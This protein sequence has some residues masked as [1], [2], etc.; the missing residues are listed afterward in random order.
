MTCTA[1][2]DISIDNITGKCDLKCSFSYKYGNI[3]SIGTNRD[4]YLS[5]VNNDN[6]NGNPPVSYNNT[7][8][9]VSEI[10]LYQPSLHSYRGNKKD[11]EIIIVHQSVN[12]DDN[13]I[14]VC[15]PITA[16][17][18]SGNSL[19]TIIQTIAKNA[20]SSGNKTEIK[21]FSV[22]DWL[23]SKST[24]FYTYQATTP[25][26]PCSN[27]LVNYIVFDTPITISTAAMKILKNIIKA[28]T[29][30]VKTGIEY[31]VNKS[32]A[33]SSTQD[34]E[35]YIDCQPTWISDEK[36]SQT[37]S[38]SSKKLTW[39]DIYTNPYFGYFIVV[40][41]FIIFVS[42]FHFAGKYLFGKKMGKII[43]NETGIEMT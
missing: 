32:G 18:S 2:I 17:S 8:F 3:S 12:G 28:N 20:P 27:S 15:I 16:G 14:L 23:P 30:T 5:L 41:V 7:K 13:P 25:Y 9:N 19:E 4:N 43:E 21:S 6:S 24:L 22:G 37:A 34:N 11:A 29:Y 31:F 38:S 36:V 42:L 40:I 10:R 1:P 26:P 33:N 35:I 39:E